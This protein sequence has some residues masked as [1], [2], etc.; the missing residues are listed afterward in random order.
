[1]FDGNEFTS[2]NFKPENITFVYVD[3]RHFKISGQI[4]LS[5]GAKKMRMNNRKTKILEDTLMT[6]TRCNVS[7]D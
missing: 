7:T 5:A 1:M 6:K 4:K 2:S 3:F